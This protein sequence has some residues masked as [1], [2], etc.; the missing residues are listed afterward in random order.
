MFFYPKLFCRMSQIR[1]NSFPEN[2]FAP[3][4]DINAPVL[5]QIILSDVPNSAK[6]ISGKH[7]CPFWGHQRPVL[8]PKCAF[9]L[10]GDFGI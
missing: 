10:L 5:A 3:F 9:W 6:L 1:Q 4:G 8:A 7:V 2:M